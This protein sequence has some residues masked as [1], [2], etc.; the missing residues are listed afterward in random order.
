MTTTL[1][2]KLPSHIRDQCERARQ[3]GMEVGI[4]NS[5]SYEGCADVSWLGTRQQ[6]ESLG[7]RVE[8][9][10]AWKRPIRR[11]AR[12]YTPFLNGDIS[13]AGDG[14]FLFAFAEALTLQEWRK[15]DVVYSVPRRYTWADFLGYHGTADALIAAG[16][17]Y[18]RLLPKGEVGNRFYRSREGRSNGNFWTI[19]L[20]FDGKLYM[21]IC[22]YNEEH[23]RLIASHQ[24]LREA[25][26][27]DERDE[28]R[29]ERKLENK[30][31]QRA[32]E[33]DA[34]QSFLRKL[35]GE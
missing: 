32:R 19:R 25:E 35:Q 9:A 3:V 24:R 11:C 2:V 29:I 10:D 28:R 20:C 18:E 33:D 22:R 30:Q 26:Q 6:F 5:R 1:E 21:E 15:D 13:P 16:I 14:L 8:H 17:M 31:T 27:A 7:M 34:F 23:K 12:L 4:S